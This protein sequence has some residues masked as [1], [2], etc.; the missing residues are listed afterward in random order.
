MDSARGKMRDEATTRLAERIDN[1]ERYSRPH[2]RVMAELAAR[3]AQRL[4]LAQSDVNAVAEASLLHDIGLYAQSPPYTSVPGPLSFEERMDLWRHPIIGEQQMAKRNAPRHSQLLVRWHHE[5]WNG[6]GYPDMLAFEDIPIGARILRAIEL[7]SSLTADRPYRPAFGWEEAVE[8]LKS[9]AGIECDPYVVTALLALLDELRQR[10]PAPATPADEPVS[11]GQPEEP[12]DSP[13]ST[14]PEIDISAS[15]GEELPPPAA[16]SPTRQPLDRRAEQGGAEPS[17][18]SREMITPLVSE[19]A[20]EKL[21]LLKPAIEAAQ[22]AAPPLPSIELLL[23]H[24]GTKD[25]EENA[26]PRWRGW[27]GTGYNR[28]SL[29]GFEASVLRQLEFRSIAIALSGW[30]RL[31]WYLKMW[32]KVVYAN[33]PRAWAAAVARAMI[34]AQ[35]P[36]GDEHIARA[37][38]DVYVPG[39]NLSNPSLRRWF[40]ETD[41]WWLDNLRRNV[42]A[43][44]DERLRAQALMLGLQAGDYALSF[45][46]ETRELKRPLTA[47]FRRLAGR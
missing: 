17:A 30:A 22:E 27:R 8:A 31:G 26:P 37:L 2:A 6:S 3:L 44:D 18:G 13:F 7:L 28:K 33:D 4:G 14:N 42:N 25:G 20:P 40:G 10:L 38:E 24:A 36:L 45:T 16:E 9:S 5:W 1:F 35:T 39:Y 19:P 15:L 41:A 46:E 12:G 47:V 11:A 43:L 21:A 29:L 23:A 34:E 32:G